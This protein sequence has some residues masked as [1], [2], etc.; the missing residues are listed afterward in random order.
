MSAH[1]SAHERADRSSYVNRSDALS[2]AV[3]FLADLCVSLTAGLPS[4]SLVDDSHSQEIAVAALLETDRSSRAGPAD[5][6][7]PSRHRQLVG[8][9]FRSDRSTIDY[10]ATRSGRSA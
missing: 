6:P 4:A 9:D 1:C 10:A 7:W 3:L 2:V 8:V 5:D